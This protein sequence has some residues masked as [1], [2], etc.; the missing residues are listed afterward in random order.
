MLLCDDL[1]KAS[2]APL[3]RLLQS[4]AAGHGLDLTALSIKSG[5][6]CGFLYV[7]ALVLNIDGNVLDALS[8]ATRVGMLDCWLCERLTVC[9]ASS[10]SLSRFIQA[11]LA[12]ASIPSVEVELGEDPN[13]QPEVEVLDDNAIKLDTSNVPITLTISQVG[14]MVTVC[15]WALHRPF[16]HTIL[17]YCC[18]RE[19]VPKSR[20]LHIK[21]QEFGFCWSTQTLLQCIPAQTFVVS[22]AKLCSVLHNFSEIRRAMASCTNWYSTHSR[23][24]TEGQKCLLCCC[25]TSWPFVQI[26]VMTTCAHHQRDT[27]AKACSELPAED[28]VQPTVVALFCFCKVRRLCPLKQG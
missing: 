14:D 27:T 20:K 16:A 10:H 21:L 1:C 24:G 12:N 3:L 22:K 4:A 5:K 8:M 11:A 15:C 2:A 6:I 13:D 28:S 25:N 23:R 17:R 19:C 26:C 9:C 18:S 7:D